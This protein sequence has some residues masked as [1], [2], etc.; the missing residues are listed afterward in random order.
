MFNQFVKHAGAIALVAG[1]Q[2]L[3]TSAHAAVASA[4]ASIL[5][6]DGGSLLT[7][8]NDQYLSDAS[9]PA[10]SGFDASSTLQYYSFYDDG[11]F[12]QIDNSFAPLPM[13]S[14]SAVD[15]GSGSATVLWSFDWTATGTGTATF[16]AEYLYSATV[17]DYMSG[18]TGI[19]SASISALLEGTQNKTELLFFFNNEDGNAFGDDFLTLNFDVNAGDTGTITIAVASNAVAAPAVPVPAAAWLMGSAL[20]GLG[21]ARLRSVKK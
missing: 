7:F 13:T 16:S 5:G 21:G 19:A 8:A 1:A 6:I 17:A 15:N 20:L 18:E 12:A 4:T 11:S 9:T 3:S 14:A 2:L 10:S